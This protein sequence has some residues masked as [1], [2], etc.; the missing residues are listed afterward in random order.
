MKRFE[1]PDCGTAFKYPAR[2]AGKAIRC[3]GCGHEHTLPPVHPAAEPATAPA[4]PRGNRALRYAVI[5]VLV[6]GVASVGVAHFW[7]LK[8]GADKEAAGAAVERQFGDV[9]PFAL[10]RPGEDRE[11]PREVTVDVD[12]PGPGSRAGLDGRF[13]VLDLPAGTVARRVTG[14]LKPDRVARNPG[15]VNYVAHLT[16]ASKAKTGRGTEFGVYVLVYDAPTQKVLRVV[17]FVKTVP[18]DT[19]PKELDDGIAAYLNG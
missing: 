6:L 2:R 7:A 8:T 3:G 1:C 18:D 16:K 11:L 12:R 5:G 15:E 4:V 14:L 17:R 10:W 19:P 13:L 9:T